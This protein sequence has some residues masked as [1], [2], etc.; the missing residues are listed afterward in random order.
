MNKSHDPDEEEY[1]VLNAIATMISV[2][3]FCIGFVLGFLARPFVG[4]FS[5]GFEY[6]FEAEAAR[7]TKEAK[8]IL[9]YEEDEDE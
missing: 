1:N 5:M 3:V 2:P 9:N 7:V 4:G 6:M 8:A